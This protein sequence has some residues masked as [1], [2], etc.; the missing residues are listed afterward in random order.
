MRYAVVLLLAVSLAPQSVDRAARWGADLTVFSQMLKAGQYA[1]AKRNDVAAFD[2]EI[3]ALRRDAGT[4]TDPDITLRLM[5]LVAAA[6][7]GHSHVD[8]PLFAPF[9]RLP[10]TVDWYADGLA[11]TSAAAEYSDALGLRV[12][13]IGEMTPDQLLAAAA[14]YI[15]HENEFALRAESPGYLTTV[16]LL[17][18]VGVADANGRVRFTLERP[19]GT[20]VQVTVAPG[21]PVHWS[22]VD[23]FEV[24]HTPVSVSRRHPD[25]RYY[26]FEYLPEART[27]YVQYNICE[28]DPL[29][30]FDVFAQAVLSV[31]GSHP[32][33]RWVIDLW[34]NSGGSNR[35]IAPL[36]DGL[37]SR[38][39]RE[40]I[41][42]LI[43]GHTFSAAVDAAIDFKGRLHA[44]LVGGPTGG[45]PNGFGNAKTMTLPNSRLK[46]QYSTAYFLSLRGADPPALE[47]D[48]AVSA[49]LADA[50][51]G[52]DA[53][54]EAALGRVGGR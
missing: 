3:A 43:G 41:A 54:L 1:F 39:A 48:V 47:P 25:Q 19:D 44:T 2:A 29:Q 38:A 42:V 52:R 40:P 51:A 4:L 8:L 15:S 23:A 24:R 45:R 37:A 5:K 26:W 36:R 21:S 18:T 9:R 17:Q 7:D 33:A 50:L 32:V 6:N 49:T 34:E 46:V 12:T 14:P 13:R 10:I 20:P 27:M 28:N 53:V 31:A 35:L 16:E 11:V 30:H 22:L